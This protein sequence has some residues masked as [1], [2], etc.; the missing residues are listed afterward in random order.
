M[1]E[2]RRLM[3]DRIAGRVHSFVITLLIQLWLKSARVQAVG[4]SEIKVD[5]EQFLLTARRKSDQVA[6][7]CDNT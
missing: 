4:F 1:G 5:N 3:R 6:I 2:P 7:R